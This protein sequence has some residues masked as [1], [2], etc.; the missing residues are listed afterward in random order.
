MIVRTYS[1]PL[2][3]IKTHRH[4]TSALDEQTNPNKRLHK[5]AIK[6]WLEFLIDKE[7]KGS[8]KSQLQTEGYWTDAIP[9]DISPIKPGE[10][11]DQ[12]S[13]FIQERFKVKAQ[14]FE[15]GSEGKM[16]SL[17]TSNCST[18][19]PKKSG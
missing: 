4:S 2:G 9:L 7:I 5:E 15:A 19:Q 11:L 14:S 3:K 1:L 18:F 17:M 16:F 6:R 12:V 13:P 10:H 8:T